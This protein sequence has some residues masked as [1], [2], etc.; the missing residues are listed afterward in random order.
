[1]FQSLGNLSLLSAGEKSTL[2][3]WHKHEEVSESSVQRQLMIS[4]FL[5]HDKVSNAFVCLPLY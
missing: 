4:P 3:P 5:Y 2:S 1:M